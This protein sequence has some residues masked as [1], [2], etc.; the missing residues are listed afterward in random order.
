MDMRSP[1]SKNENLYR[2]ES[3]PLKGFA[4]KKERVL[5]TLAFVTI[6]FITLYSSLIMQS[7]IIRNL[8]GS[9]LVMGTCIGAGML[10]LPVVTGLAG[11]LPA[12]VIN[13]LCCLFM[14]ATGLL[15]LEAI[16]WLDDGAN[17]LTIAHHFLGKWGRII[18]GASFLFLYYCLDV[19]YCA[20]GAPVFARVIHQITGITLTGISI[21]LVFAV[22][23]G[24]II[25]FGTRTL[26]RLNWI[27]MIALFA[28][29]F[30]LICTGSTQVDSSLLTRANWPL[31]LV[32]TPIL[33][34]AYGYHNILPSLSTY[35]KRNIF[36]LRFSIV[37][38]TL[39]PFVLYSVWQWMIIGTLTLEQIQGADLR[40]E[41]VTQTL[42][43]I[44]G[45]QWLR[46]FGEFFGFFA[47][48]TSFLGVSLSMVDFLADGLKVKNRE[49]WQRLLL[50]LAVF[51]PPALFAAAYP[52]IF[53]DAIGVAGGYGEAILNGLLP[54]TIVWIGR[55]HMKIQADYR[56]AGGRSLLV[57]LLLITFLIMGIETAHLIG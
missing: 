15:F 25:F 34:G 55:Y 52:R 19:S 4:D 47:L 13:L 21:Y 18:C 5:Y 3:F 51:L 14:M 2:S 7:T 22:V 45:H 12:I 57:V 40:G 11:F 46:L 50:C 1:L 9:L 53:I 16:L 29:F 42:Q 8:S 28:S 6:A 39:I 48:I 23:F 10:A 56:V 31:S 43:G 26:N 54:V 24:A 17:V 32:A 41:P 33:F 20:G 44:V 36:S 38:G 49:G 30:L 27:L 37:L 35:M